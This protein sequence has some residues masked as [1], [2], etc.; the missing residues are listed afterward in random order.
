MQRRR[1]NH[2]QESIKAYYIDFAGPHR[3]YRRKTNSLCGGSI[4]NVNSG[5]LAC[6]QRIRDLKHRRKMAKA[7]VAEVTTIIKELFSHSGDTQNAKRLLSVLSSTQDSLAELVRLYPELRTSKVNDALQ[8]PKMVHEPTHVTVTYR[9]TLFQTQSGS[10][11]NVRS[12]RIHNAK[13]AYEGKTTRT[14]EEADGHAGLSL[15]E[16]QENGNDHH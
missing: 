3:L 14:K 1:D 16:T 13:D 7:L 2:P 8:T 10:A 6:K 4:P 9:A 5:A 11:Q 12:R 15:E